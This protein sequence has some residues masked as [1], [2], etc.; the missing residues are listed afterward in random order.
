M[1]TST[2]VRAL[3]RHAILAFVVLALA[4]IASA[5]N[6]TPPQPGPLDISGEINTAP[7]RIVV[8]AAWNG[9]LLV[10]QRGWTDKADHQGETDNRNPTITPTAG[11]RDA[12][13]ARGYALAGS[14][15]KSNGYSVEDG[16]DDVVALVSYFRE[17][18]AMPTRTILWGTSLGGVITLETAERNGGAFDGYLAINPGGAGLPR[19]VD[20]FLVLRLA[21]DVT[22]GMP[23]SWGTPGD[24]RDDLDYEA[25]VFPILSAQ[26]GDPANLGRFE[27][28]RLVTGIP[29]SGI[30]PPHGYFPGALIGLPFQLVT[31]FEAELER[32]VGGP[33]AQN[34]S[35]TYSLTPE[36]KAYLAGLGVDA[37]PLLEA[38]NARRN[39]AAGQEQRNYLEHFADFS[40]LIKQ[41]VLTVHPF[42]DAVAPVTSE[43]AY[44][45]T[46]AA[47]GR[48]DLLVQVYTNTIGH[49][50]AT[51]DQ[52]VAAIQ[53]LDEWVRT[54]TRPDPSA[55]P[56]ALGFIPDF[57]PPPWHQLELAGA[58]G[59]DKGGVAAEAPVA[60][61]LE[62]GSGMGFGVRA[63]GNGD[64]GAQLVVT[65]A[66]EG[67]LRIRLYDMQG[68]VAASIADEPFVSPGVRSFDIRNGRKEAGSLASGIYFYRVDA[69]EGIR[70]GKI[71]LVR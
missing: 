16:L 29:G 44:R 8:P 2:F 48:S 20:E 10:F 22:F 40:G 31:E 37:D 49:G 32:R 14:A 43:S 27:F 17:N 23:G 60:A 25:E 18:M 24:V 34:I 4:G 19:H 36:E 67:R 5:G 28:L 62:P 57:V 11:I 39:I 65:T 35:H 47:A 26:A 55:F 69:T 7:F 51:T 41:P 66:K 63:L 38:M 30:T 56:A 42:V 54:G 50:S 45:N 33:V 52:L 68:R 53:A 59:A 64:R 15:R 71:V 70:K 46:I 13:L 9:T 61:E 6:A 21:Y 1:R 58:H 3:K 12:L